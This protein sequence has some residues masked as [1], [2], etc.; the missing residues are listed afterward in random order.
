MPF[1]FNWLDLAWLIPLPPLLAFVAII[2]Y[3]HRDQALSRKLVINGMSVALLLALIVFWQAATLPVGGGERAYESA[4]IRWLSTGKERLALGVYVDPLTAVMLFTIPLVSLIIFVYSKGYMN[5]GASQA[6]WRDNHFFAY[7]SLLAGGMLGMAVFNNLLAFF[8][9]W[10]LT[11]VGAYLLIGFRRGAAGDQAGLKAF[12]VTG[13]GDLFFLLGLALLYAEVGSLAYGD[14]FSPETLDQ[15]ANTPCLGASA[16]TVI[17]LLLFGGAVGK[18]AQFPLHVWLPD[19]IESPTPASAMIQSAATASAGAFLIARVYPMFQA[20]DVGVLSIGG[21]PFIVFVGALT[22]FGASCIAVA[23]RDVKR[24][25]TFSTINQLG[26]VIAALGVGAYAAGVFHLVA[27]IFMKALLVLGAGSLIRGID[28]GRQQARERAPEEP[29]TP[30]DPGDLIYMG[31]LRWRMART[32]WAFLIGG[33]ALSLLPL[34]TAS[35]WSASERVY[36]ADVALSDIRPA[37]WILSAAMGVT[38]LYTARQLYMTFAGQ[39]RTDAAVYASESG[40]ALI[41]PLVILAMCVVCLGWLGLPERFP[42]VG[43]LIPRWFYDFVGS[44]SGAGERALATPTAQYPLTLGLAFTFGGWFVGWLIYKLKPMQA[45]DVDRIEAAMRLFR[46]GWFHAWL[47]DCLYIDRL[48]QKTFVNGAIRLSDALA[49]FDSGGEGS[50]GVVDG[51]AHGAGLAGRALSDAAGWLDARIVDGAVNRLGALAGALSQIAERCDARAIDALVNRLGVGGRRV[52]TALYFLDR[53]V[54][55][56]LVDG[57]GQLAHFLGG[58]VRSIQTGRVQ[59]YLLIAV[60]TILALII[61][62][63]MI[64]QLRI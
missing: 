30:F 21:V 17:A 61:T 28:R 13:I 1:P 32:Y 10:T 9:F 46:L 18:S 36:G 27:H 14:V 15:L 49:R 52:S 64:L 3:A 40:P 62:F 51:L 35:F 19:V 60:A 57:I 4:P 48:Y 47:S 6:N 5:G 29:E 2:L 56:R 45:G 42:L 53:R 11:S 26:Y 50:R 23:Q 25:L 22:A 37:F 16:A 38:A 12:I 33:L 39:P 43:G 41:R 54:I 63:F 44:T 8:I 20:A 7:L 24:M 58:R 34:V 55:D 31:G 59:S